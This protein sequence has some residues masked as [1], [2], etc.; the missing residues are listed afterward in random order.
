MAMLLVTSGTV[1][2]L[3]SA[4]YFAYEFITFRQVTQRQVETLGRVI[5]ANSTAALA[6]GD[7]YDAQETISALRAAPRITAGALYDADG[8]LFVQYPG[9]AENEVPAAPEVDGARFERNALVMFYP[10]IHDGARLGTLHLRSD[11]SDIYDRFSVYALWVGGIALGALLLAYLLSRSLQRQISDPIAALVGTAKAV[12]MR[13]DYSVRAPAL[14][15]GELAHLTNA[16]NQMLAQIEQQNL[17]LRESEARMRAV[18]NSS[19][20]AV[21]LTD[22][23]GRIL[24]WSA[25]AEHLFGW[26]RADVVG[27]PLN[28]TILPARFHAAYRAGVDRSMTTGSG[29]EPVEFIALRRDGTEFPVEL[30]LSHLR[31][32]ESVTGCNFITDITE[33]KRAQV[34]VARLNEELEQRVQQ[35]TAELAAANHEL[36]AFS[37]SVSHDLRAPLRHIDGFAALMLEQTGESLDPTAQEYLVRISRAARRMSRLIEDLLQFSRQGR[38]PLQLGPVDLNDI[39]SEA[40]QRIEPAYANRRVDWQVHTLPIVWGDAPLL[41]QVFTNLIDNALKYT[42]QRE[43]ARIEIGL[44]ARTETEGVIFVRDNGAGFDMQYV[45]RLFG[46]FQRLHTDGRFE[47]TGV[48]L[49]MV[50][51]IVQRHGGRVWA[52]SQV[53]VG[54]TF[55]LALCTTAPKG[56]HPTE[57]DPASTVI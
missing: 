8:R 20:N 6:F 24:D 47:G 35:R 25:R 22:D 48:G 17:A 18:L 19:L 34:K 42:G 46:V 54:S 39:V 53:D 2:V 9:L 56:P 40:R 41:M 4:A 29:G 7:R 11:L 49:A 21:I 55:Y 52:D 57:A 45:D 37:Y 5:A 33:R 38:V 31:T 50:K 36:E 30:A 13:H 32:G 14:G 16:L 10:V 28:T 15:G 1:I 51:R 26:S 3:T 27:R 23:A 44:H 12:S 43:L